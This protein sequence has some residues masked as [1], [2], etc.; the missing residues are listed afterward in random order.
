MNRDPETCAE[1]A[2]SQKV[3]AN[4]IRATCDSPAPDCPRRDHSETQTVFRRG[5][6]VDLAATGPDSGQKLVQLGPEVPPLL[7]L[8]FGEMVQQRRI[9]YGIET[10]VGLPVPKLLADLAPDSVVARVELR[11]AEDE[12]GPQPLLGALA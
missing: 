7:P 11:A 6:A 5:D 4:R 2:S 10:G 3:V 1:T 9:T 12:I 8:N